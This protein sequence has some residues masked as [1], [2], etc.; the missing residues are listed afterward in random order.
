PDG[1]AGPPR[2]PQSRPTRGLGVHHGLG[3]WPRSGGHLRLARNAA[4][5]TQRSVRG[6]S[7]GGGGPDTGHDPFGPPP[8]SSPSALAR[9]PPR[10]TLTETPV[11]RLPTAGV[12]AGVPNCNPNRRVGNDSSNDSTTGDYGSVGH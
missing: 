5:V 6:R 2:R 12:R 11:I 9:R 7:P 10:R 4:R 3:F 8:G 1:A